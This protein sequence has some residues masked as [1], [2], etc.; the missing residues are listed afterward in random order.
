MDNDRVKL[1]LSE[2]EASHKVDDFLVTEKEEESHRALEVI[3]SKI[4]LPG[5]LYMI[6]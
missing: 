3:K 5:K 4:E 1:L 2:L 6:H